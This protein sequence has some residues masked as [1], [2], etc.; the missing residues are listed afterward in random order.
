MEPW[1]DNFRGGTAISGGGTPNTGGGTAFWP[2]PAEFNHCVYALEKL[3]VTE[4]S[5]FDVSRL[6]LY[7]ISDIEHVQNVH[8]TSVLLACRRVSNAAVRRSTSVAD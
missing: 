1:N 4:Q 3:R 5:L 2:V 7:L 8:L 6:K